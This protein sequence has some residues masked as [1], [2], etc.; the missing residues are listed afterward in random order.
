MS[1]PH[2]CASNHGDQKRVLFHLELK[3]QTV[4]SCLMWV[5]QIEL[6]SSARALYC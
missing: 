2:M 1:V 6:G 4:G 3:L 5:L